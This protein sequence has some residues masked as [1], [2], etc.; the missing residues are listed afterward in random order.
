MPGCANKY[1]DGTPTG[2][3]EKCPA[4]ISNRRYWDDKKPEDGLRWMRQLA[5]CASRMRGYFPSIK[6]GPR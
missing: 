3:N 5:K 2:E 4:C 6:V 1:C